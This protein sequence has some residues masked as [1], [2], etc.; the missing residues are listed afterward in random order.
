MDE[1][2]KKKHIDHLYMEWLPTIQAHA[3]SLHKNYPDRVERPAD[4]H[5]AG[6]MGLMSA[7]KDFDPAIAKVKQNSFMTYASKKIKGQ[8]QNHITGLHSH[9]VETAFDPHFEQQTRDFAR[10]EKNQAPSEP[11]PIPSAAEKPHWDDD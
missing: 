5:D 8:M 1:E 6:L 4:L 10:K 11:P 3:L 2:T 7:F 9:K